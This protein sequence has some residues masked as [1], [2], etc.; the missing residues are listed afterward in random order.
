MALTMGLRTG[1]VPDRVARDLDDARYLWIDEGKTANA[2]RPLEVPELLRSHPAV[3]ARQKE[4][5][6]LLFP[7]GTTGR[8]LG[9]LGTERSSGERVRRR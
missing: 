1:E 2:R 4:P 6:E 3:L 5:D 9:R 7:T 8:V